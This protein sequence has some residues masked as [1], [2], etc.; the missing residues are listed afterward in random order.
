MLCAAKKRITPRQSKK[1]HTL[2]NALRIS[3]ESYRFTLLHNFGVLTSKALSFQQAEDL[4]STLEEEA[5]KMGVWVNFNKDRKYEELGSR[6]DMATPAQL[7][8]VESLWRDITQFNNEKDLESTLRAFLYRRFKISDLRF[9]ERS[10]VSKVIYSLECIWMQ[11]V[12]NA[13]RSSQSDC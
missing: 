11:K 4:I 1:I 8:K 10:M 7:R 13:L 3:N 5:I 2:I 6:P 9:L 12:Q